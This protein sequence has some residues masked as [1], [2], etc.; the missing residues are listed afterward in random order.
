MKLKAR[1]LL[2][3]KVNSS[4]DIFPK[5]CKIN[6]PD[7]V[8]LLWNFEQ[9][10]PAYG[11]AEVTRDE[12]G[13]IA[14][15]ETIDTQYISEELLKTLLDTCPFGAGGYYNKIKYDKLHENTDLRVIE[16]ATLQ[17]IS[18]TLAPVRDEYVFHI[19]KED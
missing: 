16:E 6:I 2:F 11:I 9:S 5:D 8:P 1:I 12:F 17:A 13:L 18:M 10:K 19:M 14:I 15:V 3:D 4:G 7:K